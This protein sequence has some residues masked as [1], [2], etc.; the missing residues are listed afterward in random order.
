MAQCYNCHKEISYLAFTIG[1][2][3]KISKNFGRSK[4]TPISEC[5]HCGVE[6]QETA[7]TAYGFLLVAIPVI[8]GIMKTLQSLKI[9]LQ[10]DVFALFGIFLSILILNMLWW[11]FVSKVRE[12]NW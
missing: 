10:N 5:P 12:P 11:K 9:D 1:T 2:F 7:T 3:R 6:F 8:L 4:Q